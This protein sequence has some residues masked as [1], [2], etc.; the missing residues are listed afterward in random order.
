MSTLASRPYGHA[1]SSHSGPPNSDRGGLLCVCAQCPEILWNLC[2]SGTRPSAA[3][4]R[5]MD[6]LCTA[7]QRHSYSAYV[8]GE[9]CATRAS[10]AEP[11]GESNAPGS[12]SELTQGPDV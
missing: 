10:L 3:T 11:T 7:G 2:R 6:C 5:V 4:V 1:M 12:T 8:G 9:L